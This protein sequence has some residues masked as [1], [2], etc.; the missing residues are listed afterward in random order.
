MVVW[1][2]V[3]GMKDWQS[4]FESIIVSASFSTTSNDKII[5]C[6]QFADAVEIDLKTLERTLLPVCDPTLTEQPTEQ[7]PE[8]KGDAMDVT[9]DSPPD[10]AGLTEEK[11]ETVEGNVESSHAP[12]PSVAPAEPSVPV[13]V[14]AAPKP[15]TIEAVLSRERPY[16]PVATYSPDGKVIYLGDSRGYVTVIE[17]NEAKTIKTFFRVTSSAGPCGVK[18]LL[19]S[20]D[21]RWLLVNSSDRY[22]RVFKIE[23]Y[24][25]HRELHDPVNRQQWKTIVFSPDSEHILA[26][27]AHRH[28][29][30]FYFFGVWSGR[31]FRTFEGPKEGVLDAVWHPSQPLLVSVSAVGTMYVWGAHAEESWSS[32][33][34]GFIELSHNQE[35]IEREDEF[36]Y[37]EKHDDLPGAPAR[38][39]AKL[40]E[41]WRPEVEAEEKQDVDIMSVEPTEDESAALFADPTA[42]ADLADGSVGGL[43]LA[44]PTTV[45]PDKYI[46][47]YNQ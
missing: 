18:G 14:E 22:L 39:K 44:L 47:P 9:S 6:S 35:Y 36:D 37:V 31:M 11:A 26:S 21:L 4:R 1:D 28:D 29:H 16:T 27:C 19:I 20:P 13:P 5:V 3:S 12:Q 24:K 46:V 42:P 43:L 32:F 34:P 8:E 38:K 2:V 41:G 7:V 30:K 25:L 23:D 45:I 40:T 10:N 17:N 33:T 15:E